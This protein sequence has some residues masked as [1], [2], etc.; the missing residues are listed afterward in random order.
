MSFY[1]S[2]PSPNGE[3]SVLIG[4]ASFHHFSSGIDVEMANVDIGMKKEG[5]V[6]NTYSFSAG[7]QGRWQW[8]RDGALT[9]NLKLVDSRGYIIARFNNASWSVKKQ[10][11]F[12]ILG[13][14]D[15][16]DLIMVSGLARVEYQRRSASTRNGAVL[17]SA[18]H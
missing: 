15:Q 16:L 1:R 14:M 18:P 12:D 17:A 9:S 3:L 11:T 13:M 5:L 6:S 2:Y 4:T 8:Q 10:G 7:H